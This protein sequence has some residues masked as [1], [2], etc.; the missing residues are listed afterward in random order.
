MESGGSGRAPGEMKDWFFGTQLYRGAARNIHQEWGPRLELGRTEVYLERPGIGKA[1]G[2]DI[3]T[4][5]NEKT[6]CY[7]VWRLSP[8][9]WKRGNTI[10]P[11][12]ME[13]LWHA[14]P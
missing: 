10:P 6:A 4:W 9:P 12:F 2:S 14:G 1:E 8:K 5:K 3:C 13:V 11:T 7:Q